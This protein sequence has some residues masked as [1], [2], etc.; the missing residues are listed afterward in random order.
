MDD[1]QATDFKEALT[2]TA[3]VF[4]EQFNE[5]SGTNSAGANESYSAERSP[6]SRG[7]VGGRFSNS[8]SVRGYNVQFQN[9][10]GFRVGG[11]VSEYGVTLGGIL[12]S[13]NSERLEVVRGPS[14][15]L[16][17]IGVLSGIVNIVPKR[18]LAERQ[19]KLSTSVGSFG[20]QRH[21][22]ETSGPLS[23]TLRYRFGYANEKRNDWTDFR[24]KDLEYFVA[25]VDF[26][27]WQ[28]I[29]IFAEYQYGD[30]RYEGIGDQYIFD[31]LGELSFGFER[32]R[33]QYNEQVNWARDIGG[34]GPEYRYSGPDT[35][36]E[37]NEWNAL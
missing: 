29:N 36:E 3:G 30:T 5:S 24:N 12:D 9:R 37:R 15:L 25:Q 13:L 17:G 28:A 10:M 31:S 2:Y 16:Y 18:P 32:A 6:S 19:T 8:I 35:Y 26:Q 11:T 7:G 4:T 21:T 1:L 23:D 34:K 33:N 14:S 27:P 20:Y 22:A